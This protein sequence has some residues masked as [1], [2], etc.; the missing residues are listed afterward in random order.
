VFFLSVEGATN[1]F[2]WKDWLDYATT[3]DGTTHHGLAVT[4]SDVIIGAGDGAQVVFQLIK[5]YSNA[6]S[7]K[8]RNIILPILST[9]VVAVD[10]VAQTLGVDYSLS[11]T[12]GE[13]TFVVAPPNNDSITAGFEFDVAVRF[14]ED[15]D[16]AFFSSIDSFDSN[17]IPSVPLIEDLSLT[18]DPELTS[19]GGSWDFGATTIV[20]AITL[21]DGKAV[22][23]APTAAHNVNFPDATVIEPGGPIFFIVNDGSQTLTLKYSDTTTTIGSVAAGARAEL[24]L[25]ENASSGLKEW[26]LK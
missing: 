3:S 5:K 18:A 2:R 14:T 10:S 9:L 20:Q 11:A 7:T 15:I 25:V 19:N 8:S 26:Q 21:A 16:V 13:I 1:T 17:S 12:T 4:S 23:F 6:I 22:R 24:W